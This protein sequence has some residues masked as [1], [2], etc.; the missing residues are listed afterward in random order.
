MRRVEHIF[1]IVA[2]GEHTGNHVSRKTVS[3]V[4]FVRKLTLPYI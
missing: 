2:A 3:S 4:S 1:V